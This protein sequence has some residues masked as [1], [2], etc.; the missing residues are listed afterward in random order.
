MAT[1][2]SKLLGTRFPIIQAPMYGV[3]T[4]EMVAAANRAGC[5][6]SAALGDL[7]GESS[8][9]IIRQ[10]KKLTDC[11]FAANLFVN[12]IPPITDELKQ[13]YDRTKAFLYELARELHFDVELPEIEHIRPKGYEEQVEAVIREGVKVLSFTFGNLDTASIAL[14]KN[15]GVLLIGTCTDEQ[16]AKALEASGIDIVCVQ[17]I[18]AGGHRGSFGDED[19][20][21]IGGMALLQNVRDAVKIPLVYGGGIQDKNSLEALSKLGADGFL[22]GTLLVCSEESALTPAEKER[23]R[24]AREEDIV[25]TKSFSGRY[26]RGLKNEFIKRLEHSDYI[27]PYPYQNKLTGPFRKAARQA[28]NTEWLNLWMGQAYKNVSMESTERILGRLTE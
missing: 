25:L 16:E 19:L 28:G 21:A 2:L 5:L 9:A 8:A 11:P 1:D 13:R 3:T 15:N 27:L 4:P 20:P 24:N 10:C 23:V 6:G 14:L 26:A 17:G 7:D 22:V 18:E 12:A